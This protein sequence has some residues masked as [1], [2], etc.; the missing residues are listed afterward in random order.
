MVK[1]SFYPIIEHMANHNETNNTTNTHI[2]SVIA[3][4][5]GSEDNTTNDVSAFN[6][7]AGIVN[8]LRITQ[9]MEYTAD[10][11]FLL[12][13]GDTNKTVTIAGNVKVDNNMNV[14]GTLTAKNIVSDDLNKDLEVRL[15]PI[16]DEIYEIPAKAA[17][18]ATAGKREVAAEP[19][20]KY[21]VKKTEEDRKD[22]LATN[23]R[24]NEVIDFEK[25]K[26]KDFKTSDFIRNP[27]GEAE[28]EPYSKLSVAFSGNYVVFRG[29]LYTM[30]DI[31]YGVYKSTNNKSRP[32]KRIKIGKLPTGVPLPH[33][34]LYFAINM[35]L[36]VY[37]EP[38]SAYIFI[39]PNGDVELLPKTPTHAVPSSVLINADTIIVLDGINFVI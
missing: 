17:I 35:I 22:F 15:F 32:L 37:K 31:L 7:N 11:D 23:P 30:K 26:Y 21:M 6:A 2:N 8:L 18:P 28:G 29:I 12:L 39:N 16:S 34:E 9:N 19:E 13:D 27:K 14:D 20:Y 24:N 10:G 4:N 1:L 38:Q 36:D 3:E 5:S 33:H 25:N